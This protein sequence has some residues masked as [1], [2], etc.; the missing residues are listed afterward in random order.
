VLGKQAEEFARRMERI[1]DVLGEHQDAA[2]AGAPIQELAATA[3]AQASFAFGVLFA[4]GVLLA[5]ERE[6]VTT[7]RREFAKAVAQSQPSH[8]VTMAGEMTAADTADGTAAAGGDTGAVIWRP[9]LAHDGGV[10]I[11]LVHRPRPVV[12]A[13]RAPRPLVR[14]RAPHGPCPREAGH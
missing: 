2:D 5:A 11:C 3:D 4:L 9:D 1:T 10:E 6:R 14:G 13:G 8:M 12:L 7:T